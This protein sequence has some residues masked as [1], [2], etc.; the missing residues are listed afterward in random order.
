MEYRANGEQTLNEILHINAE[1]ADEPILWLAD[2]YDTITDHNPEDPAAKGTQAVH[3]S[4]SSPFIGSSVEEVAA[5]IQ[6][7]PKPPKP[8]SKQ[9][10]A[11]LQREKYEQSKQ[12][13]IY[14]IP[15]NVGDDASKSK[16]QSVPCPTHLAGV[17]FYSF[18][19]YDWDRAVREQALYYGE[20]A[21]WHDDD[22]SSQ[23]MALILLDDFP[24]AVCK[25]FD[26]CNQ[27]KGE[28]L[29][30]NH[31]RL[32]KSSTITPTAVHTRGSG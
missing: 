12:L 28:S 31:R 22:N 7:T 8:L 17:F 2:T 19:Q 13:L 25:R 29:I 5:F 15:E 11:V 1:E 3:D 10:F 21:T 9:F 24:T 6:A 30:A 18:D 23:L 32:T 27:T 20:G 14:H 4:W 26:T 16:L